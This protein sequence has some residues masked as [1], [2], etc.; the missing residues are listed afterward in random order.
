MFS[1]EFIK[2]DKQ[3]AL[4][5]N[6]SVI[7]TEELASKYFG[8]DDPIGKIL[9]IDG[10]EFMV[11]AIMKNFP[12][13]S[14][15]A[16]TSLIPFLYLKSKNYDYFES[17][18]NNTYYTYVLLSPETNVESFNKK[19]K[20]LI[21]KNNKGINIEISAQH[22][23]DIHLKCSGKYAAEVG[24]QGDIKYVNALRIIA[25][26]I[27][28]IACIN[29][30]NLST[31]Q[32]A[33]R[34][35]E[36]GI[37]KI[38]GAGKIR[39]IL[40]FLGESVFLVL[41]AD[42]IAMV[43]VESVLSWFNNLTGKELVIHYFTFD[44]LKNTLGIVLITGLIAGSYPAFFLSSFNPLQVLK[45]KFRSSKS[46]V[47]FRQILVSLQF[48]ISIILI[49]GTL[50]IV[51]QLK[52]I[53]NKKLGFDRENL[54]YFY[55]GNQI[56]NHMQSFKQ[57]L[58]AEPSILS[59]TCSN[60]SPANI[61]N[62]SYGFEWEG[63]ST[64]EQVLVHH[65][66]VDEDFQK[67]FKLEMAE[68]EFY[69]AS[70][71][72]D[73][74]YVVINQTAARLITEKG[75]VVGKI[76]TFW[77]RR[78]KIIGV[79]KDFNFKSVHRKIEPLAMLLIP[80]ETYCSFVRIN[81]GAREKALK[82]IEATF[83]KYDPEQP[84]YSKFLDEDL[85]NLYSAEKRISVIITY[86]SILAIFISC[87][88]LFGLSLFTIELKTKEIGVRKTL[89]ATTFSITIM[90]LKQYYK[91][92]MISVIVATPL[93]WYTMHLW[94]ENFAYRITQK[95]YEFIIAAVISFLIASI[96]VCSQ[97]IRAASQNPVVSLRYE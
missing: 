26:F 90:F 24:N 48:A 32:S 58:M 82:H 46:A 92:L 60:Q 45:G 22:I 50:T 40:Q 47:L 20:D 37:K 70:M 44:H 4:S 93:A 88:G 74:S 69:N 84:F 68:G 95:P 96:T 66:C 72:G 51:R 18:G 19:I 12:K 16:V 1:V 76:V 30:M 87:L 29:F 42:I 35:K 77:G 3:S 49:I 54:V 55:Y 71:V 61:G 6:Q 67:T 94:L 63:K 86:F 73:S 39:L 89:G 28:L 13:N 15:L 21:N 10:N 78:I 52:F 27:L 2:G 56:K 38:T 53:Q 91:W 97:A 14:H 59:V 31:A 57:E 34:A 83:K 36:V 5:Q 65:V 85:D 11:T 64:D 33:K 80:P 7:L 9:Q 75:P 41:I 23:G 79:V 81:S 25:I 62:S 17:W 43:L 8:K